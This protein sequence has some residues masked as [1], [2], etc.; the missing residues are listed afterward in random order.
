MDDTATSPDGTE[1][2]AGYAP[3]HAFDAEPVET[4]PTQVAE[5]LQAAKR[6]ILQF[7]SGLA[8]S[9]IVAGLVRLDV[10][11][12]PEVVSAIGVIVGA[13]VSGLAAWAM[14]QPQINDA[15]SR[16][17]LGAVKG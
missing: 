13:G 1:V 17:G 14:G 10:T 2:A 8:A 15:L 9:A 4:V 6:T 11:V 16:I 7:I 3:E 12:P 5:P